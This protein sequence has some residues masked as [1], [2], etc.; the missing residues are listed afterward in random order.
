MAVSKMKKLTA[1]VPKGQS[2]ALTELLEQLSCVE[3]IET[4]PPQ[5]FADQA[6][7][8]PQPT[9]AEEA[10]AGTA[11][12]EDII[13]KLLPYR[14]GKE[15][16]F[17]P[18]QKITHRELVEPGERLVQ[19]IAAA[20][21]ADELFARIEALKN[22]LAKAE[23]EIITLAPWKACDLPLNESET[24]ETRALFGTFPA[25]VN[26]DEIAAAAAEKI[27][28]FHYELIAADK[29]AQYVVF[30]VHKGD[31]ADMLSLL[32]QFGF[33]KLELS[34]YTGTAAEA[35]ALLEQKR[36]SLKGELEAAKKRLTE[37]S[38]LI[39]ELRWAADI[40]RSKAA[41]ADA[42]R[43][44]AKT[45]EVAILTGWVPEKAAGKVSAEL[46]KLDCAY[47]FEDPGP[48]DEPPTLLI[49][50]NFFSPFETVIGMYSLPAYGTFDPTYLMSAFYFVI[51]GLMLA[52]FVY[53]LLLTVGGLLALRFLYLRDG[54]K[55]LVKLFAICGVSCMIA[56][57]LFGGY[58]GDFPVVFAQNMLGKTINSPA[59][60]FDPMADPVKFLVVSLAVGLLHLLFGMGIKFY[61][62][63]KTGQP[64]AA[65]FD[66]GSWFLVYGGIGVYFVNQ[67]AGLIVAGIGALM[68]VLSQGRDAKNPIIRLGKG[69]L[70]L[71]NIVS[72]VADL[73]SYSR[74]MA[75]G[76]ASAVIASVINIMSTLAGPTPFGYIMMVVI[77][78]GAN[79]VNLAINLLGS[80]VH[81]SRLQYIEFF[82]KFYEDGGRAFK[83]FAPQLEYTEITK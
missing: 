69:V 11:R 71:Y 27:C 54:V 48:E 14:A 29:A 79:L 66:V 45:R 31:E 59:L 52:D 15:K 75:L 63:C 43:S 9:D 81:T 78:I 47:Y 23:S 34:A 20:G 33:V 12:L 74:I 73:L 58:L 26:I 30:I 3:I 21:K 50:K 55:R 82:G 37:L 22:E 18:P 57:V 36:Q 61:V 24:K 70:S 41:R 56:G 53:G 40:L 1:A 83:P 7:G 2:K 4:E 19:A 13:K 64:F 39:P 76:M 35:T 6:A 60:W 68:L 38:E 28:G 44:F 80:F 16:L 62:L 65:V 32:S 77:V 8:A 42:E 10:K 72:F 51:F 67:T 25:K 46:E 17:S 49:N 5:W